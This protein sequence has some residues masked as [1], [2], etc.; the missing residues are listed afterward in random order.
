[1]D[2]GERDPTTGPSQPGLVTDPWHRRRR[3]RGR[4]LA[5]LAPLAAGAAVAL[6]YVSLKRP[7]GASAEA[8]SPRIVVM[9]LRNLGGPENAYFADG[10]TDEIMTRL[11]MVGGLTVVGGQAVQPYRAAG[12]SH[13]Q[14][15]D[16]LSADYVLDGS[17]SW[18]P[19]SGGR[20]RVRVRLQLLSARDTTRSWGGVF[21][22]EIDEMAK[23]S[24]LYSSI[25]QQ[26]V[27]EL[28][29][30]LQAPRTNASAMMPT[31]DLEA[32]NDYLRGR[33]Y[34][35]RPSTPVNYRAA[36]QSLG[37]AVRRDPRF[38]LAYSWLGH[39]NTDAD[40]V[41]GMGRHHLDSAKVA[42]ERALKLDPN[43]PD[44]HTSLAHYYYVCCEN[45]ERAL[46]HLTKGQASR[47]D[48]A[49]LVMFI[50]NVHK[51]RGQMAEAIKYYERAAR[52][53]P[54]YRWPLN[55]LGHA[56]MWARRYDD[57]ERTFR[58]VLSQEPQDVFAY[59]HL[60]WLLVLRDGDLGGAR[61]VIEEATRSSEGTAEMRIPYYLELLGRD[62]PAALARLRDPEPGLTSS[63]LN[64]WLISD[65]IRA[66]LV[67]RLRGDTTVSSAAFESARVELER[68][69][70]HT[71][72]AS[73]RAQLWLRSG[74][75][76]VYAGLERR[77]EAIA[78]IG[79]VTASKPLGVDAIEG[80]KYLQHVALANTLL[81]DKAAAIDVL[82][83]LLS[84]PAPVSRE[85]LRLEPFWDPL[86]TDP[87]FRQ[88]RQS[89]RH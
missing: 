21:E 79:F 28:D 40:W 74:L 1:V 42:L 14:I 58:R 78:Q 46:W 67:H 64:E 39:A 62:Y 77:A 23:L 72:S 82:E 34:L 27:N 24:A 56:Q 19:S 80:P 36:I 20:G 26:V 41:G 60:A 51:R 16:A 63:H 69:L 89:V 9:P 76:I 17:A 68:T 38:A 75:A 25:A 54:L 10:I 49:R 30:V 11:A 57:A 6:A 61:R 70:Q 37:R 87:R 18:Q 45:Y 55:N 5:L 22:D 2:V 53:D 85:S 35:R 32:Y 65:E 48:D 73:R 13:R 29:V 84:V 59:A 33:E 47:P 8:P 44:G 83:R 88:L 12:R 71:S 43:L 50:G 7:A 86:R 66:A 3:A 15:A 4:L 31:S 52:L 81:G